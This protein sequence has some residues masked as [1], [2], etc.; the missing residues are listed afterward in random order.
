MNQVSSRNLQAHISSWLSRLPVTVT[1]RGKPI[2]V[3]LTYE[4]YNRLA[5]EA[6]GREKL[7][8]GLAEGKC[9]E[10]GKYAVKLT[11][12]S[13]GEESKVV[14]VCLDC[15]EKVKMKIKTEGGSVTLI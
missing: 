5:L 12:I 8:K 3:I 10:C 1:R 6:E 13:Y 2:A 9:D 7:S 14:S 11:K 15:F 4:I